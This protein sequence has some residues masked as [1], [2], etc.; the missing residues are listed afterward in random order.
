MAESVL[1]QGRRVALRIPEEQSFEAQAI[2]RGLGQ[3]QQSISRMTNFFAEQNRIVAK[4]EGE[5]FGAA[6][7]PTLEQ[8]QAARETGEELKLPG[9]N[10]SLFGRAARQAAATVVSS[11]IEL[12]ARQEM[13]SVLLDFEQRDGN[14]ADLMDRLDAI[15]N[16]YS[17]TFDETVPS[18]SR[19]MKAKLALNANAK[20]AS[21]HSSYI[22]DQQANARTAWMANSV[23]ELSDLPKL[24]KQGFV[25]KDKDGNETTRLLGPNE[26][27]ALKAN[28]IEEM[29]NRKFEQGTIRVWGDSWDNAVKAAAQTNL[30]DTITTQSD[31]QK[32][33]R[34][35][36][37]GNL[38]GL[39][40]NVTNSVAILRDANVPL[41][42]IAK[43]LRDA[44]TEQINFQNDL[45]ENN[46]KNTENNEKVFISDAERALLE[47]NTDAF[48]RAIV[49]LQQTN[50]PE[51]DR[52]ITEQL[53]A[54]GRRTV[55]DIDAKNFLIDRGDLLTIE[56]V[57][58]V[59]GELSNEDRVAFLNKA[60]TLQDEE[61][62]SAISIM[63]G[64][65]ELPEGYKPVSDADPN[66]KKAAIFNRLVGR[67][68]SQVES[69]KRLG[70][71]VDAISLV[72]KLIGEID[73]EF[74][75]A[76]M[77]LKRKSA[78]EFLENFIAVPDADVSSFETALPYLKQLKTKVQ[79]EGKRAFPPGILTGADKNFILN[80]LTN[81][82]TALE[83][84]R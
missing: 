23:F 73:A 60:D 18:M 29:E 17:A 12:A 59:I 81:G 39:P 2:E 10:N 63:R 31:P 38:Q 5:E 78:E 13:N 66:F 61:T 53:K 15:V 84:V 7:A 48:N 77:S 49:K 69:A 32:F 3:L 40:E 27:A 51:A 44:V 35:I 71:D 4:A 58:S 45:D 20:Y 52:L 75:D 55:S 25:V 1:Y 33:I 62:R 6:N 14:P 64:R 24:L 28:R 72:D 34:R 11:E 21:Y 42:E 50:Q 83:G 22:S 16:G 36:Q 30:L 56:D 65:F 9:N 70:K 57:A 82:I 43:S 54:G 74:D 80:F 79:R 19:S 46:E 68:T 47:G 76:L 67:L 37:T 41:N 26:I 8:I